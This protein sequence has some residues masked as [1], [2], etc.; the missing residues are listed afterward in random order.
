MNEELR[1]H[2]ERES[3]DKAISPNGIYRHMNH[4]HW[5][6]RVLDEG[7]E[8]DIVELGCWKG[9]TAKTLGLVQKWKGTNK[10]LHLYDSFEGLPELTDEDYPDSGPTDFFKKGSFDMKLSWLYH[11]M[12]GIPHYIHKGWFCETCPQELPEKI[13]YAHLDGDTYNSIKESLE[14]V[15]PRLTKGAICVVDDYQFHL[16]PGVELAVSEF[17]ADKPEEFYGMKLNTQNMREHTIHGFFKKL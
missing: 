12:L 15:Y 14:Y 7:I 16:L 3:G 11:N 5:L 1:S 6:G 8:G 2:F 10:E 13:A 17:M 9:G 4:Y